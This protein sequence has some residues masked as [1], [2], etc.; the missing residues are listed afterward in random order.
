MSNWKSIRIAQL[1]QQTLEEL[2][3]DVRPEPLGGKGGFSISIRETKP[4]NGYMISDFGTEQIHPFNVFKPHLAV[5]TLRKFIKKNSGLLEP[6]DKF[7]GGWLGDDGKLFLDVSSNIECDHEAGQPCRHRWNAY[8]KM[9]QNKQDAIYGI[10]GGE[11]L[12]AP[13]ARK[14]YPE[15][16]HLFD[17]HEREMEQYR[18]ERRA[19][20]LAA[21]K[22]S[23][24]KHYF[25]VGPDATD[26]ELLQILNKIAEK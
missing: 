24:K 10:N 12:S 25:R 8:M 18:Q 3:E 22:A 20:R 2:S 13:D 17:Q 7:F 21:E 16:A 19:K 14:D 4:D 6:E 9:L 26:E 15:Y 23:G 11:F 1:S 5:P